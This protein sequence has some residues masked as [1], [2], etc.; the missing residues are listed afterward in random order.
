MTAEDVKEIMEKA[1]IALMGVKRIP[2]PVFE[3]SVKVFP[4]DLKSEQALL[5][6]LSVYCQ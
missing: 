4:E 5:E 6:F 3:F 2:M 1:R